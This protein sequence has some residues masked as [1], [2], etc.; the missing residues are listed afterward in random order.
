VFVAQLGGRRA[1]IA[2]A[3][4]LAGTVLFSGALYAIALGAPGAV[5]SA[6]PVGGVLFMAGWIVLAWACVGLKKTA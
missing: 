1:L 6:I 5:G 3:M 4:F 2:A